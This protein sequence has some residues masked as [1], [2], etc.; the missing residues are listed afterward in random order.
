MNISNAF[1]RLGFSGIV[2]AVI[3]SLAAFSTAVS[4]ETVKV[5]LSGDMEVPPVKTTA[6]GSGT[7]TI[8]PDMSVSGTIATTGMNGTM[9]H[10]HQGAVGKNGP[11]II[12]LQK[13]GEYGWT[14]PPGAKLT[15]EQYQAFKAGDLYVNVHSAAHP[16]GEIR[17][18]LMP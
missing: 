15:A 13:N 5:V 8:N 16:G 6:S 12:P 17:A 10:I 14:P 18:Q 11:V 2:A 9:A 1:A 3:I 4:A 7:I